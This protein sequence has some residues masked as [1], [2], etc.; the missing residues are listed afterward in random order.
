MFNTG[1]VLSAEP[2]PCSP[3]PSMLNA[4]DVPKQIRSPYNQEN[5]YPSNTDCQ[6]LLRATSPSRQIILFV[7]SSKL[8]EPLFKNC[9]D[10]VTARDGDQRQSNELKTWCGHEVPEQIIGTTDSMFLAFHSDEIVQSTG[11]IVTYAEFAVPGCPP[12]WITQPTSGLSKLNNDSTCY[13]V[14]GR[15][16]EGLSWADAQQQCALTQA[17]LVTF[18][19]PRDAAFVK[20]HFGAKYPMFWTGYNSIN[21]DMTFTSI[22]GSRL[23]A[24]FP[25]VPAKQYTDDCILIDYQDGDLS[26]RPTDCR[27][28]HH[29][30]CKRRYDGQTRPAT[31][32]PEVKYGLQQAALD[33]TYWILI[34]VVLILLLLLC[35]I[36]V[37]HCKNR[38]CGTRVEPAEENRMVG[39]TT[40][41]QS[42]ADSAA[43]SRNASTRIT[44]EPLQG[45]NVASSAPKPNPSAQ[46]NVLQ[47]NNV[48]AQSLQ[49][50]H[51]HTKVE[52]FQESHAL[53][54]MQP[55][56]STQRPE[57][58]EKGRTALRAQAETNLS[59]PGAQVNDHGRLET[60]LSLSSSKHASTMANPYS[61][62]KMLFVRPK[63]SLLEHSSAI[64]L[65]DFW[66]NI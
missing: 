15:D 21:E 28:K 8:E 34:I 50:D 43:V 37:G 13:W 30:V 62:K 26:Y 60:E 44:V 63:M 39:Q 4:S 61:S 52:N 54:D 53:Q 32:T 6:F 55:S 64:S 51:Q 38:C 10:Y 18:L 24:D 11:F 58:I 19:N 35:C 17:N 49:E 20:E 33:A 65:D 25:G 66:K 56:T 3:N 31:Q 45:Q 5:T 23:P 14:G 7:N 59:I 12:G 1:E 46:N 42:V 27:D 9:T 41:N 57:G 29:F 48:A 2:N 22:D 36:A 16:G 40:N 47:L